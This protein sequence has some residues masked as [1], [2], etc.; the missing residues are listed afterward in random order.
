MNTHV[1]GTEKF[2]SIEVVQATLDHAEFIAPRMR[3][4]DVD[5]CWASNRLKPFDALVLGLQ[6]TRACW[7]GLY[8]REPFCM[9]G[10]VRAKHDHDVGV[11]WLLATDRI[12]DCSREFLR[13]N[14]QYVQAMRAQF[15]VLTNYVDDRNVVSKRWLEWLGFEMDTVTV[16]YGPDKLP[17][18]RFEMRGHLGYKP[19]QTRGVLLNV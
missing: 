12:R 10:V 16:P 17:F 15:K 3:Q 14:G 4:A 8:R 6:A 5:E 13:Q 11:V 2:Q 9:F 18:R 1:H 19:P 7:T